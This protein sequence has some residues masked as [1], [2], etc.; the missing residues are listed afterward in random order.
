MPSTQFRPYTQEYHKISA[1][2]FRKLLDK[3]LGE[4]YHLKETN[5]S[6]QHNGFMLARSKTYSHVLVFN[7]RN[8]KTVIPLQ[9]DNRSVSNKLYFV[10]PFCLHQRIHM[11]AI[12]NGYACRECLGLHYACQSERIINRLS[13]RILKLRKI[14]WGNKAPFVNDLMTSCNWWPKPK[15]VHQERYEREQAAIVNLERKFLTLI[16]PLVTPVYGENYDP[17][18]KA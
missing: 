12:D 4:F 15:G 8:K 17:F 5:L 18:S 1:I 3:P 7:V 13:R 11:Y 2:N 9:L 14:L 10:C 6:L 16:W